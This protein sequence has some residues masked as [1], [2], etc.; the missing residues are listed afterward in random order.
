M[1]Y[2][3]LAVIADVI[4]LCEMPYTRYDSARFEIF[5][6]VVGVVGDLNPTVV[7]YPVKTFFHIIPSL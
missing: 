5:G 6:F 1:Q 7:L 3:S 2:F 4:T